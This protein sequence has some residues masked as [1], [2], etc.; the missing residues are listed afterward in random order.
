[1]PDVKHRLLQYLLTLWIVLTANFLLPRM[2]PGDPL[3][4]LLDPEN[5]DYVFDA[6]VRA[7]LEAYYG[8]DRPLPEQY[9]RYMVGAITG[10][11][12]QSIRL[13][14]PVRELVA[15]HLP[16]TLLLATTALGMATGLSIIAGVEAAWRRGSRTDQALVI[17]SV[18]TSNAPVYFVGMML[19][20]V[21]GVRLRWLPLAGGK[22]PFAHY[23]TLF[24][25][26]TDLGRHLILP[27]VTLTLTLTGGR[28]LLVRNSMLSILGEDFMHVARAKGL[29]PR[30]LKWGHGL[31]NAILPFIAHMAAHASI[32]VTGA[33]FIETLFDYP[34]MGRLIFEAVGARDY[35][36]IQGAFLVVSTV[37]LTANLLGDLLNRY[38]DPRLREI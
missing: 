33:V 29:S 35:P 7:A 8:L 11:M 20:I 34:G 12:G 23:T 28:F 22:T 32:A 2:L 36:V 13:N 15:T 37:V 25:A 19:L 1:M 3:T 30:R 9:A 16:W 6:Q 27:A 24:A 21:F 26:V 31:R 18:I 38:L 4:A 14:R 17:L 5:S 10:D